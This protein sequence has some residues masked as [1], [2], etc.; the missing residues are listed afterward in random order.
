MCPMVE[1]TGNHAES[2]DEQVDAE[3][4]QG[5]E[6]GASGVERWAYFLAEVGGKIASVHE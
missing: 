1:D 2:I 6:C 4:P 5:K 3:Q